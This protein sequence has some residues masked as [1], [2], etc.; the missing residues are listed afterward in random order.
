[1]ERVWKRDLVFLTRSLVLYPVQPS[2]PLG[3]QDVI[4]KV[5]EQILHPGLLSI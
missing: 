1:M 2:L 4:D 3:M 5:T